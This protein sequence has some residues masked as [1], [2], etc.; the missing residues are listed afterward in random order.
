MTL[1]K[2]YCVVDTETNTRYSKFYSRFGDAKN[3]VPSQNYNPKTGKYEKNERY[4]AKAFNLVEVTDE[5][6][7]GESK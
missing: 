7:G 4:V 3:R 5:N 6:Q 2:V 1:E